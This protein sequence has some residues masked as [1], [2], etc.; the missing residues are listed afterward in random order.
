MRAAHRV[1]R[2]KAG[3]DQPLL[4]VTVVAFVAICVVAGGR[5]FATPASV[6]ALS[7]FGSLLMGVITYTGAWKAIWRLPL[8]ARVFLAGIV[9]WPALQL[10]PLP[11][12]IWRAL[13]GHAL[14]ATALD[15][16]GMGSVWQP[17]TLTPAAT[18]QTTLQGL[19]LASLCVGAFALSRSDL[20]RVIDAILVLVI[21]HI[22]IGVV[23]FA[24]KGSIGNFLGS[25]DGRY[26][27]GF[28]GNKN[29]SALFLCFGLALA[30]ARMSPQRAF[31]RT[32]LPITLLVMI[33]AAFL[34]IATTSRAGILLMALTI[35]ALVAMFA[36]TSLLRRRSVILGSTA[37]TIAFVL[38][39]V[40]SRT[41]QT[42]F[43]HFGNAGSDMRF[44]FWSWS[45]PMIAEY[46]PLGGG[47]GIYPDG[48][49]TIEKL[50]WLK[51]TYV[52]HVHN[53]YIELL[54]EGGVISAILL[55][56]FLALTLP[57]MWSAL[58]LRKDSDGR[59]AAVAS[60]IIVLCGLHSV[61]DYPLRRMGI[62]AVF[63]IALVLLLRVG[64]RPDVVDEM[65]PDSPGTAG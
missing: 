28:F 39:A 49:A 55:V 1:R 52:N 62:A 13:P 64:A 60:L 4:L 29:H 45:W 33:L 41:T 18:I 53:E 19:W 57:R 25:S 9:L 31:E 23:Q 37:A 32:R 63:F 7:V 2:P 26:L 42:I 22:A 24:S 46:A 38:L 30:L 11:P 17:L 54:I 10:L 12:G 36:P 14:A 58:S 43:A 16:V 21:L 48:F 35:T 65:K 44:A 27:I 15:Q 61:V 3:P 40:S 5:A 6:I 56:L 20:N 59:Y 51:P 34:A 8:L 50:A 47:F